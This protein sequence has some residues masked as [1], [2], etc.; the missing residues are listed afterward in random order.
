MPFTTA[1]LRFLGEQLWRAEV[2]VGSC[3]VESGLTGKAGYA[4]SFGR[5]LGKQGVQGGVKFC[6]SV[7]I[8][9]GFPLSRKPL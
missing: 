2:W 7:G 1:A 6:A 5:N 3:P 9:V 4:A 8:W